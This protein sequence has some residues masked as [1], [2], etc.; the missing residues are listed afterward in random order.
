MALKRCDPEEPERDG[1]TGG[2]WA[3]GISCPLHQPQGCG[4]HRDASA[5]ETPDFLFRLRKPEILK[6]T[7]RGMF[8]DQ[9]TAPEELIVY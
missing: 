9:L 7:G 1:E 4:L 5:P 3:K 2:G 8:E 6:P